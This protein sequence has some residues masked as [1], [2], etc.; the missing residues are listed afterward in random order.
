[1]A[2]KD[3]TWKVVGGVAVVETPA[4]DAVEVEVPVAQLDSTITRLGRRKVRAA[5]TLAEAQVRYDDIVAE[6]TALVAIR[7]QVDD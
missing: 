4:V 5:A 1:M 7:A 6:E 2:K 3:K